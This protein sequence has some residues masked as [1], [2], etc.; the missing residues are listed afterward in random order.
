MGKDL[1]FCYEVGFYGYFTSV[2][3]YFF[4]KCGVNRV[5]KKA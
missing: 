5:D 3:V 4:R 2:G 1:A